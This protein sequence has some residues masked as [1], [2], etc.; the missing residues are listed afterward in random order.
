MTT[1][2]TIAITGTTPGIVP[3][4]NLE[5]AVSI[6]TTTTHHH[7]H[8]L[9]INN[10]IMMLP[11]DRVKRSS[12]AGTSDHPHLLPPTRHHRNTTTKVN[13][14]VSSTRHRHLPLARTTLTTA[15]VV[16]DITEEVVLQEVAII[17]RSITADPRIPSLDRA[18][19]SLIDHNTEQKRRL[20]VPRTKWSTTTKKVMDL[21]P[22][23]LPL[24]KV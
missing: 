6:T 2:D 13:D 10:T 14:I 15:I 5:R 9:R 11:N 3:S 18:Q 24:N 20:E 23:G 7:H 16:I 4:H 21:R 8:H 1:I 19:G 17:I 12:L 22:T